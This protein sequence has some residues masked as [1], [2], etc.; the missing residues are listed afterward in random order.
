MKRNDLKNFVEQWN[1]SN[2]DKPTSLSCIYKARIIYE[3]LGVE[4]L[5]SSRG[6]Y[7][8]KI[9]VNKDY[10]KGLHNILLFI[11]FSFEATVY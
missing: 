1:K 7:S 10:Y 4:G 3:N 5:L 11:R 2:P 9:K 6:R 8:S